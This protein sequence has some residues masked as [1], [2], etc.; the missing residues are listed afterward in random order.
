MNG[1]MRYNG[2]RVTERQISELVG[3]CRG[4]IADGQVNQSEADFVYK[5]L[6]ANEDLVTSDPVAA[7]LMLRIHAMLEDGVLDDEES[8]ELL[9]TLT[10]FT[11]GKLVLGEPL[12]SSGLPLCE[13]EPTVDFNDKHFCFTGTFESATRDECTYRTTLAGGKVYGSVT[14]KLDYLVI[15]RFATADWS[16]SSYGRKIEKAMHVREKHGLLKIIGEDLW[17]NSLPY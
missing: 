8:V 11:G 10:N 13:P 16:N 3:L 15:G 4:I 6:V 1:T 17:V 14:A 7:T 12:K 2:A 9:E 5:W